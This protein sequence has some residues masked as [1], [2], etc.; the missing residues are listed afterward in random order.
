MIGTDNVSGALKDTRGRSIPLADGRRLGFAEWG[1]RD[2]TP[3]FLFHGIPGSRLFRHPDASLTRQTGV[4]LLTV[5]RPGIGLSDPKPGRTLR[6][7]GRDVVELA[8]ALGIGEFA[9]AGI[10]GGGPY[11]MALG[12]VHGERVTRVGLISSLGHFDVPAVQAR[13]RETTPWLMRIFF[14]DGRLL[15]IVLGLAARRARSSPDHFL[16]LL[17]RSFASVDREILAQPAVHEIYVRDTLETYRQGGRGHAEDMLAL[18][19]PWGFLPED[20]RSEVRL[21]HGGADRSVPVAIA[22]AMTEVLPRCRARFYPGQGHLVIFNIWT[23]VLRSLT[24]Q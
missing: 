4:R 14:A 18:G 24:G 13:M 19:R 7:W 15:R 17:T 20:L 9:V 2:G 1:E 16:R 6:A 11:A 3:V 8:D 22:Q 5:D 21:W 10:S 12:C 23:D